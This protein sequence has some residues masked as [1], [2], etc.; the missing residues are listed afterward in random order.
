MILNYINLIYRKIKIKNCVFNT[1]KPIL[2]IINHHVIGDYILFR[3]FIE[4][5][6][7]S[8]KYSSYDI[9]L[10]LNII[11]RDFETI[12][13]K[14]VKE[15]IWS[16][17]KR[18]K[19]DKKYLKKKLIEYNSR[20]FDIIFHTNFSRDP[21]IELITFA[22][23]SKEKVAFDSD[24]CNTTRFWKLIGNLQYNK[25]ISVPKNSIFEFEKNKLSFEKIIDEKIKFKKPFIEDKK[26]KR[27][28]MPNS[29]KYVVI[30]PGGGHKYKIWPEQ[31]YI[32]VAK[33]LS[34]RYKVIIV[35]S[36]RNKLFDGIKGIIN[37]TGKTSLIDLI[38]I[39]KY[40]ELLICNESSSVHIGVMTNVKK[41]ICLSHGLIRGRFYPYPNKIFKNI[42][43]IY[44]E[45]ITFLNRLMQRKENDFIIRKI[46]ILSV[47]EI[48]NKYLDKNDL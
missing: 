23:N 32:Y 7:K 12:D 15:F 22:F 36:K 33:Y 46:N 16:D 34:K 38:N 40:S 6:K 43:Y 18:L 10:Y 31:K 24:L 27:V 39:I 8:K 3:N 14:Y 45:K 29:E 2:L 28:I 21:L 42:E 9:C 25:I 48:I 13:N 35:D 44:P 1:K 26:I 19:E 37:L 30:S 4:S 41:I 17:F 5:I 47:I 11:N 20:Y